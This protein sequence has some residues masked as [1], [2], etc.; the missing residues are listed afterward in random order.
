MV[1]KAGAGMAVFMME[2]SQPSCAK[3]RRISPR[4]GD[5]VIEP[6]PAQQALPAGIGVQ[7]PK[8]WINFGVTEAG[9][10]PAISPFEPDKGC[11]DFR[12]E[13]MDLGDL[14]RCLRLVLVDEFCQRRV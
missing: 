13:S 14:V 5:L 8:P 7:W 9:I 2:K 1:G 3:H 11:V 12:P 10:V 4:G 6:E